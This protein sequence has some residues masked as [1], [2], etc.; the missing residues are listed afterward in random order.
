MSCPKVSF[1]TR[2]HKLKLHREWMTPKPAHKRSQA[3]KEFDSRRAEAL[4][5]PGFY[6]ETFSV[7]D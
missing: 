5:K 6:P 4:I 2:T 7:L 3:K 1:Q